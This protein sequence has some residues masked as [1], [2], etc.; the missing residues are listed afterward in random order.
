VVPP[1]AGA[2]DV[3]QWSG[4]QDAGR[5]FA[6]LQKQLRDAEAQA[7]YFRGQAE[8]RAPQPAP[9]EPP[10]AKAPEDPEPNPDHYPAGPEGDAAYFRDLRAWDR[11]EARREAL[12]EV[13]PDVTALK[14]AQADQAWNNSMALA[15]ARVGKQDWPAVVAYANHMQQI[16]PGWAKDLNN[17]KDPGRFAEDAWRLA[18]GKGPAPAITPAAAAAA[19]AAKPG[20]VDANAL[21]A[22]PEG[23]QQLARMLAEQAAKQGEQPPIPPGPRGLGGPGAP[24]PTDT[25]TPE[26]I[27]AIKDPQ[28]LRELQ[29]QVFGKWAFSESAADAEWPPKD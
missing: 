29:G 6:A 2:D 3:P 9:V 22:T 17:A 19:P 8:A 11:R 4:Q 26:A 14:E 23:R 25:L 28:K 12:A 21:L 7:A 16:S 20:A 18:T 10:K 5:A 1:A 15:E 13:L 24:G 27:A